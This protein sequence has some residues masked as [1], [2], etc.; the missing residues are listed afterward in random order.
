MVIVN[1]HA[2]GPHNLQ[3]FNDETMDFVRSFFLCSFI[4]VFR[5]NEIVNDVDV[6]LICP[7]FWCCFFFKGE[8]SL[9]I[10]GRRILASLL[11]LWCD[12]Y[13]IHLR[14]TWFVVYFGVL[15]KIVMLWYVCVCGTRWYSKTNHGSGMMIYASP[16][17]MALCI[18]SFFFVAFVCVCNNG[19]KIKSNSINNARSNAQNKGAIDGGTFID[20]T[21]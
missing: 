1:N 20:C 5:C 15:S 8:K 2:N 4:Y 18:H 17:S 10:L 19:A 12:N 16:A 6:F 7:F 9:S 21:L 14:Q 11:L 3:D 13:I